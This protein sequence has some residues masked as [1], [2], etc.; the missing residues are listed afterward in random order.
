MQAYLTVL[1]EENPSFSVQYSQAISDRALQPST[2][3][4]HAS[5]DLQLLGRE[6]SAL[7]SAHPV[8]ISAHLYA[9]LFTVRRTLPG[10]WNEPSARPPP[11]Q[12]LTASCTTLNQCGP[13]PPAIN[14]GSLLKRPRPPAATMKSW[15]PPLAVRTLTA[16]HLP[17]ATV[18][19]TRRPMSASM[20][21]RG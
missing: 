3:C 2:G 18:H 11:R 13:P 5:H 6:C 14:P 16:R 1:G 4:H 7:S 21:I 19:Y 10:I 12:P 9:R 15:L 17:A 8:L 20:C